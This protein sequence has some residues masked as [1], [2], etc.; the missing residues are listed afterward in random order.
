MDSTVGYCSD[1]DYDAQVLNSVRVILDRY[2]G[3]SLRDIY[4][5][6]YQDACGPGHMI[7]DSAAARAYFDD[8]LTLMVSKRYYEIEP[9]GIG[10]NYCRISMDYVADGLVTADDFYNHFIESHASH[11]VAEPESWAV[12]WERIRTVM[13]S[14]HHDIVDYASDLAHIEKSIANA[15][16]TMRH[17]PQYVRLYAPHYRIFPTASSFIHHIQRKAQT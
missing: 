12:K 6:F 4:K 2:P 16:Y 10:R 7:E 15:R 9:C 3:A 5:S 17:S 1:A 14:L 8:E 13:Q 11:S